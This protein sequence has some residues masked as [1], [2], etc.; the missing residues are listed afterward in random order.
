MLGLFT[1]YVAVAALLAQFL[2]PRFLYFSVAGKGV[3]PYTLLTIATFLLAIAAFLTRR[4]LQSNVLTTLFQGKGLVFAFILFWGWRFVCDLAV[5][6]GMSSVGLT[7]TD[8]LYL[9]SWFSTGLIIFSD[10]RMRNSL[11]YLLALTTILATLAGVVEAVTGT[12]VI[13]MLG[14][15]R[16]AAGD[17][18]LNTLLVS[19]LTRGTAAR[20]HSLFSHPAIYGQVMAAMLPIGLHLFL[21]RRFSD[22]ALGAI[23][24]AAVMTSIY[25]CNARSP[26]I[27]AGVA[28]MVFVALYLFDLRRPIRLAMGLLGV[29]LAL[30]AI[31]ATMQVLGDFTAG[32]TQE[33]SGSSNA[34]NIQMERGT[35]ALAVSPTMGYGQG[36]AEDHAS[37]QSRVESLGITVRTVDNYYLTT[38]VES[39][40]VGLALLFVY[41]IAMIFQG[42]SGAY[43]TP[44]DS[45]RTL[46][47]AVLGSALGLTVGLT[48]TSISDTLSMIFTFAGFLAAATGGAVVNRR[49]ERRA[50]AM[51]LAAA[52]GAA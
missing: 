7:I 1:R 48:I 15:M 19:D 22:K 13:Q 47:C 16:F 9:G 10:A 34:R 26:V 3:N 40:Y 52:E 4:T 11:P 42:F 30:A 38:A 43:R 49:R 8:F 35:S 14:L 6:Q 31:P 36:S 28:S 2:W 21:S 45:A 46:C 37:T 25:L 29:C 23:T 39:G 5:G 51:R 41:Y 50:I 32:R 18:Y 17:S 33:E 20:I 44:Q 12:Q 27:V 24:I